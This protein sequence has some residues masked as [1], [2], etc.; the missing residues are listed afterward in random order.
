MLRTATMAVLLLAAASGAQAELDRSRYIGLD[1]IRPGMKAYCLTVFE[2]TKVEKFPLEVV[3]VVRNI[4]PGRDAILVIG[5]DERFRHVGPVS[6]NSGSPVF[7]DGRLAGALAFAW[8][9]SKDPLYGVT[10]IEEMLAVGRDRDGDEQARPARLNLSGPLDLEAIFQSVLTPSAPRPGPMVGAAN[11]PV[12]LA[13]SLPEAAVEGLRKIVQPY[14]FVPVA[15][16]SRAQGDIE[17]A[18]F[19]PGSAIAIP[20][21]TGDIS[22]SAVGTVTEVVDGRFYAF[23]HGLQGYGKTELPIGPAYI[24]TVV[25]SLQ[26]SFKLGDAAEITG[27]LTRD[28]R[29][30][31]YGVIGPVPPMIDMRISVS[32]YN[33]PETRVYNCRI[34]KDDNLT[35]MLV[36]AVI[37]GAA[38]ARGDFPPENSLTYEAR[39]RVRGLPDI[40][41]SNVSTDAAISDLTREVVAPVNLL[42]NNPYRRADI[43][44]IDVQ[45]T[46]NRRST[47]A[48]IQSL[49]VSR[50][51]V[52]AGQTIE[53]G[54]SVFQYRQG[55]RRYTW[56][57][58]VPQGVAPGTYKLMVMGPDAYQ[59]FVTQAAPH[60]FAGGSFDGI[61]TAIRNVL[62]IRRDRIYSVLTLPPGGVTIERSEMPGLPAS[63]AALL[64]DAGRALRTQPVQ[65]WIEQQIPFD[66]ILTG[67]R[68]IDI[69]VEE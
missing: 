39:I 22:M 66:G 6:G 38:E 35:P 58:T 42:L 7:I 47:A 14:G 29:A 68:S 16:G 36:N 25:A 46:I 17:N 67:S 54:A 27:M 21:V 20:L 53:V 19:V 63:K 65:K 57:V 32:R 28:E 55:S 2:G 48:I 51:R 62:G 49:D 61:M 3:S 8:T 45:M 9:L 31:V 52:R 26:M 10:P 23:G 30:A 1:E 33:D 18:E 50:N 5:T 69:I 11:L 43:E 24:H 34:A 59:Q 64:A 41:V 56:Q 44:S 15:G 37:N 12:P 4:G 40:Y 13:V 60:R